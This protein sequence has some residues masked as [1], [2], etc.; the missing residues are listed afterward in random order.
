MS[1]K[2]KMV[3]EGTESK[4]SVIVSSRQI[5]ENNDRKSLK[6]SWKVVGVDM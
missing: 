1:V 5:Q 6:S 4:V 2:M 3:E